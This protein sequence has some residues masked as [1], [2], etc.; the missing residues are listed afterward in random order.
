MEPTSPD[1]RTS[2]LLASLA[3]FAERGYDGTSMRTIADRAGRP[4]SLLSHH[5]GNKNGLYVETF[6]FVAEDLKRRGGNAAIPAEGYTPRDRSEAIR[7]LRE[8]VHFIVSDTCAESGELSEVR[9]HALQ[10]WLQEVRAPRLEIHALIRQQL[11]P[12]AD[13]MKRCIQMLRPD[14]TEAEVVF[15][16]ASILGGVATHGLMAGLN[17][18]L[19]GCPGSAE[20]RFRRSELLVDFCLLG[21]G[22]GPREADKEPAGS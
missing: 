14:L 21:L 19:W 18:V 2:L 11:G 22:V 17:R 12:A 4:L 1:T 20:N 9:E 6:K 16:G 5:F 3:C 8:Q 13:T 10:L 7:M 15:L